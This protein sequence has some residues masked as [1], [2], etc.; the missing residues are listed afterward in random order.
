[1][2]TLSLWLIIITAGLVTFA[3]R[4]SFIALLGKMNLPVLLERGLR[5]VPVAVLPA[6]I[7]PALF[8][9]Q[10]QLALSWDNERLVAGLVA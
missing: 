5:Y 3:V 1:M 2:S 7:A 10:G 8:F 9:Q 4:L 6:L